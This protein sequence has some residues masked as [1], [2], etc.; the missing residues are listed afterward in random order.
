MAKTTESN[1]EPHVCKEC[2]HGGEV[3]K[4]IRVH[5]LLEKTLA[6]FEAKIMKSDYEPTVAEYIK[7]LQLG[8]E[9]GQED[10]PKEI[11]VTWVVPNSTSESET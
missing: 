9:M 1:E 10:E 2:G 5:E 3:N 4:K 11:K 6:A 8:R 7:L